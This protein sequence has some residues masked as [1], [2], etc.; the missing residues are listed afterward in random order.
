MSFAHILYFSSSSF[1][2]ATNAVLHVENLSEGSWEQEMLSQQV[3][4]NSVRVRKGKSIFDTSKLGR[5]N[6]IFG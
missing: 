4:R 5:S 6:E 1:L 3:W 2:K